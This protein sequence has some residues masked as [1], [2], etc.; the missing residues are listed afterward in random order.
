MTTT[1][2][3]AVIGA[4][5]AGSS[6]AYELAL[7]GSVILI[8]QE[9]TPGHH[10]TGRSAALYTEAYER[11]AVRL[12]VMASRRH[13]A[14]PPDGFSE[15]PILKPLPM[16][17]IATTHQLPKLDE[18]FE[19]TAGVVPL[20]RLGPDEAVRAFPSLRKG[21]VSGALLE[22]DSMEIDVH[23]LHQGFLVGLRRR[24]GSMLVDAPVT[25]L[26]RIGA[27]WSVSAGSESIESAVVVNAAGAWCDSVASMAGAHPLGLTPFRR[28]AFTFGAPA[29]ADISGWPMVVDADEQFYFKPEGQ[30]FMG[31]LAEETPMHPHDVR[32]DEI[33]VALAVERIK[34]A[35]TFDLTHVR[36]TWAGLGP[37]RLIASR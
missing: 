24:G 20:V 37:L 1:Y 9:A 15:N 32:P 6:A 4:G 35:T 28:T 16:M 30:Q 8:E 2:D 26:R 18:I 19:D 23:S 12:L 31:S 11:G 14:S 5:I 33:D 17:F 13:L 25:Q 10:T 27:T 22:T 3:F 29:T 34:A 21:Y 36:R 7:H